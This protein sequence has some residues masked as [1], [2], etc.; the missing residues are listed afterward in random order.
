MYYA[1]LDVASKGSYAYVRD[2][3]GNKVE[4]QEVI[5]HRKFLGKFFKKYVNK[6]IIVAIEAGGSTRWIYD[7]LVVLGADGAVGATV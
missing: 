4:G 7:L 1:G 3:R 6:G 2:R 5:T